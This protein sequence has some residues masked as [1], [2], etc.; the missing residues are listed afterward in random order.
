MEYLKYEE[1]SNSE[2][3]I[4]LTREFKNGVPIP[5]PMTYTVDLYD[6]QCINFAFQHTSRVRGASDNMTKRCNPPIFVVR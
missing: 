3:Q 2:L 1:T 5:Y 6:S 4:G